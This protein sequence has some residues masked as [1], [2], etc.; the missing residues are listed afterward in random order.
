MWT[1]FTKRQRGAIAVLSMR[2]KTMLIQPYLSFEGRCDEA[3]KFYQAA[4]GAEV[5]MLMRFKEAPDQSMMTPESADKVMHATLRMGDSVVMATDGRCS[6]KPGFNGISLS[7]SVAE[8]GEAERVFAALSDGGQI[9][10][11]LAK[12]FFASKF[13]MLADRFGVQWMVIAGQ[14][15]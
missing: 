1:A 6:G 11:P 12:T 10:M 8:D 7:L 13:G 5:Q 9:T 4:V 15:G 14:Q 3:V 2:E